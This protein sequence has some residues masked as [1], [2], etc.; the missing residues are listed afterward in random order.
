M[1]PLTSQKNIQPLSRSKTKNRQPTTKKTQHTQKKNRP[2]KKT[3]TIHKKKH[4]DA[5]HKEIAKQINC[6]NS[7]VYNTLVK[8]KLTRKKASH[9]VKN[10]LKS[11]KT[12]LTLLSKIP[13]ENRVYIDEYDIKNA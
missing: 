12:F 6:K 3:T 8:L 11:V 2:P 7:S 4:P 13:Q 1:K 10:L 9:T 5:Y